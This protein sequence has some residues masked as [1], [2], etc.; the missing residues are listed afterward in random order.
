MKFETKTHTLECPVEIEVTSGDGVKSETVKLEKVTI[1]TPKGKK[2]REIM[3]LVSRVQADPIS[4]SEG[5]MTMDSIQ[6]MSD[7]PPGGIDELHP[8][9][10]TILGDITAPFLETVIGGGPS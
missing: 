5:D 10:I 7:M 1:S 4:Y 2:M 9:D 6:I 3:R 8:R